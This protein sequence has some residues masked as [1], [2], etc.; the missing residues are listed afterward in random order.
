MF[1]SKTQQKLSRLSDEARVRLAIRRKR[2][3]QYAKTLRRAVRMDSK[4]LAWYQAPVAKGGL[5][6]TCGVCRGRY[7]HDPVETPR[8]HRCLAHQE[9]E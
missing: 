3:R 2:T 5:Q 9:A 8:R 1:S 6:A 4:R 7:T